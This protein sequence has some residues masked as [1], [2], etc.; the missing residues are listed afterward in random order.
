MKTGKLFFQGF[1]FFGNVTNPSHIPFAAPKLMLY[2]G[3]ELL[4]TSSGHFLQSFPMK[5]WRKIA[6]AREVPYV[7]PPIQAQ[8]LRGG[9]PPWNSSAGRDPKKSTS[10]FGVSRNV[11]I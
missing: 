6:L 4:A 1:S 5:T 2:I 11:D 9:I 8:W 7:Q 10:D 3:L